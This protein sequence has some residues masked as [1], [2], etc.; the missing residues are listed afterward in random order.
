MEVKEFTIF[1]W[2]KVYKDSRYSSLAAG[3]RIEI[4]VPSGEVVELT[5]LLL[6]N[7]TTG[8]STINIKVSKAGTESLVIQIPLNAGEFKEVN[9]DT[10]FYNVDK[11]IIENDAGSADTVQV[12]ASLKVSQS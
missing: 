7:G 11:V 9:V 12:L 8:A 10:V 6:K 4:T 5:K 1:G 3:T 2:K